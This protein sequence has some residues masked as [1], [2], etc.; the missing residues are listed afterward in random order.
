MCPW[1]D[2]TAFCRLSFSVLLNF[3]SL[4]AVFSTSLPIFSSSDF[5]VI[6]SIQYSTST[7][8]YSFIPMCLLEA[9]LTEMPLADHVC[10]VAKVAQ[11]LRKGRQVDREASRLQRF[12]RSLLSAW[13]PTT[14][15]F[16]RDRVTIYSI[17]F[18]F[19]AGSCLLLLV[20][21][22]YFA[23]KADEL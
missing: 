12:Q 14:Q 22:V 19:S 23:Y 4:V 2:L 10:L 18:H 16:Q 21:F 15:T 8:A 3:S 5:S 13:S 20:D 11:L 1:C 17:V 9:S 6:Y 7:W